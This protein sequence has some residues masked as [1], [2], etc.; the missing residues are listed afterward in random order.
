M[1]P[2]L[3]I[4]KLMLFQ[5][6]SGLIL[7]NHTRFCLKRWHVF[8]F[9][10]FRSSRIARDV[11]FLSSCCSTSC[12][13]HS[14]HCCASNDI[15]IGIPSSPNI[16]NQRL[17][18]DREW[19]ERQLL[20]DPMHQEPRNRR[21]QGVFHGYFGQTQESEKQMVSYSNVHTVRWN[22][23]NAGSKSRIWEDLWRK[24]ML[25]KARGGASEVFEK[26]IG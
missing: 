18:E 17:L 2:E 7:T 23:G 20:S 22:C 21:S 19:E 26:H 13:R 15:S 4:R 5:F 14:T 11:F 24:H 8:F 6:L 10:H 1:A 3:H 9:E 12:S 25:M 16:I